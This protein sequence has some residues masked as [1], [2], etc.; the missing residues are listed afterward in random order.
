VL[1]YVNGKSLSPWPLL[2]Q[3]NPLVA[4]FSAIAKSSL[5]MPVAEYLSEFKW[6]YF[7]KPRD[8]S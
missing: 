2:I 8:L 3:P 1:V 4:V 5:L 7:K 6:N